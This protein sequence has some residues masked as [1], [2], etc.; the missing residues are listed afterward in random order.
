MQI[1][2]NPFLHMLGNARNGSTIEFVS[3]SE[4]VLKTGK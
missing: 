3:A 2:T 1:G 4:A